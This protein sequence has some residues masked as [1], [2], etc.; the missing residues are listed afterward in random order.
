LGTYALSGGATG[1]GAAVVEQLKKQG[2]RVII[3]DINQTAGLVD[4]TADLSS[5]EGRRAAVAGV[6]ALAADGL[7]GFVACAGLGPHVTPFSLIDKVNYF[8]ATHCIEALRPLVAER[9]GAVVAISSNSATLPGL[10][11]P[12]IQALLAGDEE[13]A[14]RLVSALDGHNAYAGSKNALAR[15][16]RRNA[17]SYMREG[18]RLNAIAPGVTRTALTDGVF[19]DRQFGQAMRDFSKTIPFGDLATPAMIAST[20]IFLLSGAAS[21]VSG[22]VL[23]VDGGH[24]AI[25]RPEQ[26]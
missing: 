26:F 5:A 11:E 19:A 4:V 16:V 20:V 21:F 3:T 9:K 8:G 14:C 22:T 6:R 18:I 23:F 17:P 10:D 12:H 13:E 15:W 24:D 25:L 7:D 1:I 2:H